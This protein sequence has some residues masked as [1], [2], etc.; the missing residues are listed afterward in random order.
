MDGQNTGLKKKKTLSQK[1]FL[2]PLKESIKEKEKGDP[3]SHYHIIVPLYATKLVIEVSP[4]CR[5]QII[6]MGLTPFSC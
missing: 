2:F 1:I 6:K 4:A 3:L 5:F